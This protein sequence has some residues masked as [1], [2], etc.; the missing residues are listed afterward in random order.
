MVAPF[1]H[2]NGATMVGGRI[3]LG[4]WLKPP[5]W[6]TRPGAQTD[7]GPWCQLTAGSGEEVASPPLGPAPAVWRT[8]ACT[9]S[10]NSAVYSMGS[11]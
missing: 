9:R 5:S 8:W 2:L 4:G 10:M 11:W 3:H 6:P 7:A 1:T